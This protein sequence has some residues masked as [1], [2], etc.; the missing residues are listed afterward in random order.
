[1]REIL[2]F[3]ND[4][5]SDQILPHFKNKFTLQFHYTLQHIYKVKMYRT[6]GKKCTTVQLCSADHS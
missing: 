4:Q 3:G 1:M 6:V 5:K 2:H